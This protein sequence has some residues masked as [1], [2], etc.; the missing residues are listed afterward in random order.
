VWR[1]ATESG[2]EHRFWARDDGRAAAELAKCKNVKVSTP[3]AVELVNKKTKPLS[4]SV[5]AA[6]DAAD[7]DGSAAMTTKADGKVERVTLA[8]LAALEPVVA[9]IG[10]PPKED[11]EDVGKAAAGAGEAGS[12]GH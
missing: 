1:I 2:N 6:R 8:E 5:A 7:V 4:A 9:P 3:R 11:P 10:A 12:M